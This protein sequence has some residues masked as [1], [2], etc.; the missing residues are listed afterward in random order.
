MCITSSRSLLDNTYI[1][2]WD[3]EHPNYG[4]R[5]VLAYQ[6]RVQNLTEGP[7]CMLLPIQ[8]AETIVPAWVVD[9]TVC[10]NF[11]TE[12]YNTLD[13]VVEDDGL[14]WMSIEPERMNYVVERGVYHIAILNDLSEEALLNTLAQIPINKKPVLTAELLDF[15]RNNYNQF[16]LLL[17][18][19][20]NANALQ[21]A[22][23]LVHYPPQ[24]PATLM[25]NTL[26][27]HGG[28]PVIGKSTPF[29]QKIIIG[30]Y[31]NTQEEMKVPYKKLAP[32][33]CPPLQDFLPKYAFA[34][35]LLHQ[36]KAPNK[37]LCFSLQTLHE[38][39]LPQAQLALL[40]RKEQGVEVPT[41][42]YEHNL[43]LRSTLG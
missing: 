42:A 22:P 32:D 14:P 12:L 29:H 9:S 7:N 1:G 27:S 23:I 25:V 11:L 4:Y 33:F 39:T 35:D 5:H 18:C 28:I 10:P 37:D 36:F 43:F 24:F 16:P 15:F 38:G 3:I 8:S 30:S 19:F 20:N 13:P 26:D 21:A 17:C 2:A 6:N 34:I 40:T 31:K 41:H